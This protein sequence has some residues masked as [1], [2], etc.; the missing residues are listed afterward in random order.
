MAQLILLGVI[1]FIVLVW[2]GRRSKAGK[3]KPGSWI[4]Q[5]RAVS[6]FIAVV[7]AFGGYAALMKGLIL[8]GVVMIIGAMIWL[9]GLKFNLRVMAEKSGVTDAFDFKTREAMQALGL[10]K[11][12]DKAAV[13]AAWREKMKTAHPDAGGTQKEA[14]KLNAARDHLLQKFKD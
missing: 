4:K 6:A 1:A 2:L 11:N 12:A 13:I 10:S 14:A 9:F 5:G 7:I 3:L 8:P